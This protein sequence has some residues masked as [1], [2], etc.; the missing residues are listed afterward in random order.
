MIKDTKQKAEKA[1]YNILLFPPA[2]AVGIGW[3]TWAVTV[4]AWKGDLIRPGESKVE[5]VGIDLNFLTKYIPARASL[6]VANISKDHLMEMFNLL[7]KQGY[8]N[9]NLDVT[10]KGRA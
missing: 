1:L 2:L 3:V 6:N 5:S 10:K 7:Q 4:L 8:L 9:K